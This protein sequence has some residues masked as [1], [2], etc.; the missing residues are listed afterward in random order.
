MN[1]A[2]YLVSS[3]GVIGFSEVR[4]FLKKQETVIYT[5]KSIRTSK[6]ITITLTGNHLI[7]VQKS[8]AEKF[9]PLLVIRLCYYLISSIF[10]ILN[11]SF[12]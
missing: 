7:Y 6:N 12:L 2:Q 4:G 11:W 10:P 5:Y 3:N 1:I 9:I 8:Y